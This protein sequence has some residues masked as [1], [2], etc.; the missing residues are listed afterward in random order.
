M[1][2]EWLGAR[3]KLL[4]QQNPCTQLSFCGLMSNV[5][6][7]F[8]VHNG[9]AIVR[10]DTGEA[11][12]FSPHTILNIRDWNKL[13]HLTWRLW[14][15]G[16]NRYAV[17]GR[18]DVRMHKLIT[19]FHRTDHRNRNGLDNRRCNLRRAG[20]ADNLRNRGPQCN[21]TSGFKGVSASGLRWKAMIQFDGRDIYLGQ[22]KTK[23]EAASAYDAGA[24]KYFGRFA[25]TNF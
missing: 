14:Q 12:L 15:R 24:R 11:K 8:I 18:N 16:K 10:L 9:L 3:T 13:K 20:H 6:N 4:I 23:E 5:M 2:L 21:N 17:T 7:P 1:I 19:G 25:F 22:Y